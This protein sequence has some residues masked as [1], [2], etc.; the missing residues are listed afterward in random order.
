M[1]RSGS[2]A[3][4]W[5]SSE[6]LLRAIRARGGR[7]VAI[8]EAIRAAIRSGRLVSSDP[9]PS[10]RS[11]AHELGIARGTVT[12]AYAQL[13]AEGYLSARGGSR[14]RVAA[15]AAS[16]PPGQQE[17]G[18]RA[19]AA[20]FTL[21][22]GVPDVTAFPRAAWTGA[23]R[24]ALAA[25]PDP[26]LLRGDPRGSGQLRETLA[27]HLRRTRGVLAD[28]SR[29]LITSGFSHGL[30]VLCGAL[31]DLGVDVLAVEDPGLHEH[32]AIAAR[33]GLAVCPL[34]VD[35]A[36]ADAPPPTGTRAVL[37]TPAHQFP[38]GMTL[39]PSRRTA[40][41]TW[42]VRS[43]GLIIEDDYDG[44]YRYDQQPVG[45]LQ[46][47]AP[48]R[49]V[50]AGTVSKTLTPALRI[51]WLVLPQPLVEPAL[52]VKQLLGADVSVIEQ[53]ALADLLASGA[54]DRHV[55][56]MR[57]RYRRRR[58]ALLELLATAT[59][60]LRPRGIAAGLH[61]VVDLPAGRESAVLAAARTS[62][63]ELTGLSSFWHDPV[64]RPEGIAIGYAAAPEHAY[65]RTLVLLGRVLAG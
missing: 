3:D 20:R 45:A 36:G 51:G 5:T 28:P 64:G 22:V 30:A 38:L 57:H 34:P 58:D 4:Q 6:A 19:D 47:L 1:R 9:L 2:I 62:D 35:E 52:A 39:A 40:L 13:I 41:V 44:E 56:R 61:V 7:R 65:A 50:Y 18:P 8:E 59:P 10:S 26:L 14:T 48:E 63:L 16:V 27:T 43:S 55:R 42:A 23:T 49:V 29:I 32:R 21:E 24:R 25:A 17:A 53:L 12:E 60:A 31:R 54:Y 11:L 46:A 37:V 33:A 15:V